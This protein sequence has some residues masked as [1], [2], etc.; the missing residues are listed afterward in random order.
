MP[1]R[2]NSCPACN[3]AKNGVK[4]RVAFRHTCNEVSWQ[5]NDNS[6]MPFGK[7]KGEALVNVPGGYL[8]HLHDSGIAQGALKQYIIEN[9]SILQSEAHKEAQ[10]QRRW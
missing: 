10:K 8:I 4:S 3:A 5:M 2:K 6:L 1:N 7:Y 9:R